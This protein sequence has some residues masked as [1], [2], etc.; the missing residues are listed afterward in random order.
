MTDRKLV[1]HIPFVPEH[2]WC[3]IALAGRR[4]IG[5]ND[6]VED[7]TCKRCLA[8]LRRHD[9]EVGERERVEDDDE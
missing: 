8:S 9:R 6:P 2:T 5:P 7:A 1:T 4:A 3:G